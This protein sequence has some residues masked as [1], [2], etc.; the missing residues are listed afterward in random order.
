MTAEQQSHLCKEVFDYLH[1]YIG[2]IDNYVYDDV[3]AYT[4]GDVL[5]KVDWCIEPVIEFVEL[6]AIQYPNIRLYLIGILHFFDKFRICW[7]N[8]VVCQMLL[9]VFNN[10]SKQSLLLGDP[11]IYNPYPR[12]AYFVLND[13]Y[14][15]SRNYDSLSWHIIQYV[16]TTTERP[17]S[18]YKCIKNIILIVM[19]RNLPIVCQTI[20]LILIHKK[21]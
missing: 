12:S 5:R 11:V 18:L 7:E 16:K 1:D 19:M 13:A 6:Y 15:K 20:L 9:N 4:I 21:R 17:I 3:I 2:F 14:C 10:E 8:E